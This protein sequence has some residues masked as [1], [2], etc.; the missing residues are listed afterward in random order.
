M[1]DF[2]PEDVTTFEVGPNDAFSILTDIQDMDANVRS[3]FY[4]NGEAKQIP[5]DV[6][7]IGPYGEVVTSRAS[8]EEGIIRFDTRRQ[9]PG[10]YQFTFS[11]SI[12][13]KNSK[14]VTLALNTGSA[15]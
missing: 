7:V 6:I 2:V 3:A 9:G 5:I 13:G 8:K 4:L 1:S 10:P 15:D 12:D 14:I 11:N